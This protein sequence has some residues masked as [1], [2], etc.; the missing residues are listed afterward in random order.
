MHPVFY[1]MLN[2]RKV[3]APVVYLSDASYLD[4]QVDPTDAIYSISFLSNRT[5]LGLDDPFWVSSGSGG[6]YEIRV[7]LM[8]GTFSS[9][10]AATSV[11]LSL[12]TNREWLVR[13]TT[14][15]TKSCTALYEIR[16]AATLVVLDSATITLSATVE[17][18]GG[19]GGIDP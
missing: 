7:T 9:V 2:S 16:N 3:S 19:G 17:S 14:V 5:T 15:G 13:K 12:G 18:S 11:W 1:S 4:T 8:S 10:S 6:D